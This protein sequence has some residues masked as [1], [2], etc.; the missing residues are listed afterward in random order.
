M[1]NAD[2][3]LAEKIAKQAKQA[4]VNLAPCVHTLPA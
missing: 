1:L 3:D 2:L 4:I